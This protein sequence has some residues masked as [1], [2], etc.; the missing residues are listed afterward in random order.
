MDDETKSLKIRACVTDFCLQCQPHPFGFLN[1]ASFQGSLLALL[2]SCINE[3]VTFNQRGKELDVNVFQAEYASRIDLACID[4]N[5]A[6]IKLKE[7]KDKLDTKL[8][9]I[10]WR[11]PMF[12]GIEFK[13]QRYNYPNTIKDFFEGLEVDKKKLVNLKGTGLGQLQWWLVLGFVHEPEKVTKDILAN[14]DFIPCEEE[15]DRPVIGFDQTYVV[16]QKGF[17]QKRLD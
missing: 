13:L 6:D 8:Q 9:D 12:L 3:T 17:F 10:L 15:G 2:R 14:Y 7:N 5:Q 4:K 1:E 16:T 11:L